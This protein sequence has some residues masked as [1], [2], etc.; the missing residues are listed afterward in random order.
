[1][2]TFKTLLKTII[3]NVINECMVKRVLDANPLIYSRLMIEYVAQEVPKNFWP[4]PNKARETL[5]QFILKKV[6][7]TPEMHKFS[8]ELHNHKR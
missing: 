5:G 1:M 2:W 4:K 3:S 6:H 8:A 7:E